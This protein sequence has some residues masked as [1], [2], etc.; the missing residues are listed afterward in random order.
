MLE[1]APAWAA[2]GRFVRSVRPAPR[3]GTVGGALACVRPHGG[4]RMAE[5]VRVCAHRRGN[6]QPQRRTVF[7]GDGAP[8]YR[9]PRAP[10]RWTGFRVIRRSLSSPTC[11]PAPLTIAGLLRS[12][13]TEGAASSKPGRVSRA[14]GVPGPDL[15]LRRYP[16]RPSGPT[17]ERRSRCYGGEKRGRSS[18][19]RPALLLV[20]SGAVRQSWATLAMV[21]SAPG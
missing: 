8:G 1:T 16:F 7:A 11:P 12:R 20:H 10:H 3:K 13:Y 17:L 4:C 6:C 15:S 14:L 5:P 2:G 9:Y 21:S 19:N 18:P